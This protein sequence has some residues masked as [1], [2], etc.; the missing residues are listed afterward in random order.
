MRERATKDYFCFA[1][2]REVPPHVEYSVSVQILEK[3][4]LCT[5]K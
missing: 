1:Y 3:L 5:E 4:L 2:F